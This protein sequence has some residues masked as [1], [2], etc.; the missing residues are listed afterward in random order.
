MPDILEGMRTFA[1]YEFIA[2]GV[3]WIVLAWASSAP[4]VLWPAV[5]CIV[6]GALLKLRPGDRLTWA[7]STSSAV[8]GLL[9]S[10]YQAYFWLSLVGGSF[11]GLAALSVGG[12]LVFAL[13]HAFLLVAGSRG[14]RAVI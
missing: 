14:P 5:T 2:V 10:A 13:A 8:L 6:S 3:V 11:A 4:V 1:P 9:V 7:W 12:F